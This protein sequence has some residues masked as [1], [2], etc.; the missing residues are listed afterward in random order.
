[1]TTIKETATALGETVL[2]AKEAA[3][4]IRR[5][6]S[7]MVDQARVGTTEALHSTASA[8]RS[9][10]NQGAD[11]IDS[12]AQNTDARLAATSNYIGTRDAN[13]VLHDLRTIV[14]RHPGTFLFIAASVAATV[15]YLTASKQNCDRA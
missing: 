12:V 13:G 10:G 3:Q 4:D 6:A 8:V 5:S 2:A 1:M 15:G 14:R 9:A 7:N 11:M